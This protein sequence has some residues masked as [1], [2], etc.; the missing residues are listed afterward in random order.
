M[1]KTISVL[2]SLIL[3]CSMFS[4]SQFGV[5]ADECEHEYE[6]TYAF[7]KDSN[8]LSVTPVCK[9]CGAADEE[10]K[11]VLSNFKVD[12]QNFC[13]TADVNNPD[14]K[15]FTQ[16]GLIKYLKE[17]KIVVT[18][19]DAM[20]FA[21]KIAANL[22]DEDKAA[23]MSI[24]N[25]LIGNL[26]FGG[27]QGDTS[28]SNPGTSQNQS[29]KPGTSSGSFKPSKSNIK[30]I[31]SLKKG[32]KI[33]FK[34]VDFVNG[35]QIQYSTSKKFNNKTTKKVNVKAGKTTKTIKKLKAKKKYYVR[36]RTYFSFNGKKVYSKWSKKVAKKTK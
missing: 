20:M 36:I 2:L 23:L 13:I 12:T 11:L 10:N 32:L 6:Q 3:A 35:Y 4:V 21:A 5:F 9:K 29:S 28:G 25:G 24:F 27:G 1:K 22:S 18:S 26:N 31:T 17:G 8:E 16:L 30:K 19:A 14:N 34:K 7:N 15:Y 33:K